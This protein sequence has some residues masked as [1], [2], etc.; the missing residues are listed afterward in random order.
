MQKTDD[1][2]RR[3]LTHLVKAKEEERNRVASDIHDDSVQVMTSAAINLERLARQI[4]DPAL[5]SDAPEGLCP[6]CLLR[7]GLRDDTPPR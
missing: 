5:P 3:L 2:R 7:N 6:S 1:E 4:G